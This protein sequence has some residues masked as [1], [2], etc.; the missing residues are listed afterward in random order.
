MHITVQLYKGYT[1]TDTDTDTD[2]DTDNDVH[3][4]GVHLYDVFI[5][6]KNYEAWLENRCIFSTNIPLTHPHP[7]PPHNRNSYCYSPHPNVH[8]LIANELYLSSSFLHTLYYGQVTI[9]ILYLNNGM[10]GP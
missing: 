4:T 5:I 6:Y 8:I 7:P 10:V 3:Y 9:I 1:D 2:N